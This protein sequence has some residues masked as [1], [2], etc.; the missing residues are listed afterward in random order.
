MSDHAFPWRLS[1]PLVLASA[2]Q[3]RRAL[4]KAANIPLEVR[5]SGLDERS[6]EASLQQTGVGAPE[7]ATHLAQAKALAV[8][9]Q[10]PGRLVL[11]ADQTLSCGTTRLNKP[12][13]RKA[14]EAQLHFLSGRTHNL[15][16]AIALARDGSILGTAIDHANLTMRGLDSD[17]IAAYLDAMG[18]SVTQT[19]GAYQLE[20]L[21]IHLFARIEGEH[22]TI[23][24]LPMLPLLTLL[25]QTNCLFD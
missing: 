2:S 14:A 13:G 25:R 10:C 11:A 20:G 19:V 23:L 7:L 12:E 17:F 1:E 3:A 21:G 22:S 24:G 8:S 16:A 15:H 4:L 5:P 18:D 6:L 9:R